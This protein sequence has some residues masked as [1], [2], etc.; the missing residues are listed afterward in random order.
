MSALI[1]VLAKATAVLVAAYVAATSLRKSAAGTR[2][3]VWVAALGAVIALP[4][5]ARFAPLRLEVLP[6]RVI[7][8]AAPRLSAENVV[9]KSSSAAG[10]TA[11][12]EPKAKPGLVSEGVSA[13]Q[14]SGSTV[15]PI[16]VGWAVVT[17]ALVG[18][19]IVGALSVRR[20][21]RG[22]RD[23]TTPDWTTPLCE[24][25]DRLDLAEVPRLVASDRIEM[26]FACNPLRP[27][28]VLPATSEHWTDDRRR[29]VLLHELAHV[30]RRD[31]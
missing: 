12:R 14:R 8:Q 30:R 26:A 5:L 23:L 11:T 15:S 19:L 18:W 17:A 31:L 7:E 27:T 2:H 6:T 13:I 1:L 16:L 9:A 10:V 21:L 3:L 25:A 24:V 20:I 4:L 22:S 29:A 28:I